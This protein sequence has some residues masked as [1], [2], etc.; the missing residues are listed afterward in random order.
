MSTSIVTYATRLQNVLLVLLSV[1]A[2]VLFPSM[3][4]YVQRVTL[5]IVAFL[6]YSSLVG[7]TIDSDRLAESALPV[8]AV[9]VISY[10][11]VPLVGVS[12][13]GLFLSD[14][15]LLGIAAIL[16]APATAG[17]AIVWTRMANGNAELSGIATLSSLALAPVVTPVVLSEVASG[18]LSLPIARLETNLLLVTV[19]AIL[20]L[21]VVPAD[22]VS[23]VAMRYATLLSIALLIYAGVGTAGVSRA[24][25]EVVGRIGLVAMVVFVAGLATGVLAVRA[26]GRS[27]DDLVAVFF[28][29]TLK[30]LGISMLIVLSATSQTAIF[31]VIGYYVSQQVASALL[32]DGLST[33][34]DAIAPAI[35]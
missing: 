33:S 24:S 22:A 6:V 17:S 21:A 35:R 3:A 5:L 28:S 23:E 30:N 11:V 32:V 31:A 19:A 25:F 18:S 29:G 4:P 26:I 8:A 13:A 10:V 14:G 20:L 9:L 27:R 12:W 7:V 2:G 16:S 15:M 34:I 1:V